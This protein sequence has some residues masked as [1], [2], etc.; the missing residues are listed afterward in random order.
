MIFYGICMVLPRIQIIFFCRCSYTMC[1]VMCHNNHFWICTVILLC[2]V[3]MC[4]GNIFFFTG[5]VCTMVKFFFTLYAIMML[6]FILIIWFLDIYY[7]KC[8]P[9]FSQ[10]LILELITF[11]RWITMWLLLGIVW[12]CHGPELLWISF[13]PFQSYWI[14]T[15]KPHSH[16]CTDALNSKN[17]RVEEL[18]SL[19]GCAIP[20]RF[21][22]DIED[23]VLL[24]IFLKTFGPCWEW[25]E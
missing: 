18:L 9:F 12:G 22:E 5:Y 2:F 1:F 25:W 13:S 23:T 17:F 6:F 4:L 10:S 21:N 24:T 14:R 15:H 19:F 3:N 20:E 16:V 7:S 11:S 8:F